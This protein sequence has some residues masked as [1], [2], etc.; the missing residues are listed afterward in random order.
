[1]VERT[2]RYDVCFVAAFALGCTDSSD[3][4]TFVVDSDPRTGGRGGATAST[5]GAHS[6]GA[7]GSGGQAGVA[8]AGPDVTDASVGGS[9]G[10]TGG[11]SGSGGTD[12]GADVLRPGN[13]KGVLVAYDI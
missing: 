4:R 11:A 13:G 3:A 5:G 9:G 6:G 1:M 12:G 7:P 2:R 8:D 10:G